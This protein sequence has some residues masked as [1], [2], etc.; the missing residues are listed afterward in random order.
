MAVLCEV[1]SVVIRT[2][3][4]KEKFTDSYRGFYQKIPN[5]TQRIL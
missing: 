4:I 5:N 3:A 2:K 1:I